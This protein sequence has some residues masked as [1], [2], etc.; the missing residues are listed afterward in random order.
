MKILFSLNTDITNILST[1][2][3]VFDIVMEQYF[4]AIQKAKE[5]YPNSQIIL[6]TD[7]VGEFFFKDICQIKLLDKS[8]EYLFSEAKVEAISKEDIPF[9]HLDGDVFL[10]APIKYSPHIDLLIDENDNPIWDKYYKGTVEKFSKEGI[11]K[12]FPEWA[13]PKRL[14]CMGV[15]GFFNKDLKDLF[16]E[17]YEQAKSFYYK[18]EDKDSMVSTAPIVIEQFTLSVLTNHYK[19]VY[20]FSRKTGSYLH[21]FGKQKFFKINIDWIRNACENYSEWEEFKEKLKTYDKDNLVFRHF[22][23]YE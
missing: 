13:K 18:L 16:I 8:S 20:D 22:T 12:I 6:Y 9:I 7:K 1:R 3:D 23:Y 14:F 15:V 17:R 11:K 19:Y 21:L 10:N 4:L 2:Y 5:M